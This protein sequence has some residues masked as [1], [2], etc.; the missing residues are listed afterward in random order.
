MSNFYKLCQRFPPVLVRLLAR[1]D[2]KVMTSSEIAEEQRKFDP[3]RVS[4]IQPE[5]TSWDNFTLEEVRNLTRACDLDF[6]DPK[7]INRAECYLR[8]NN[9]HPTFKYL[10]SSPEW[11]TYYLPLL[12]RWRASMREIP[13]DLPTPI[14]RLLAKIPSKK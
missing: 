8:K 1:K 4:V 12:L 3:R 5:D 2:G 13:K 11:K 6:T 9:G 14:Q 7:A 10:T